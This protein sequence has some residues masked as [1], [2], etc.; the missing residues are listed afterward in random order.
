MKL[1]EL[2]AG[3]PTGRFVRDGVTVERAKPAVVDNV[4][5]KVAAESWFVISE[6]TEQKLAKLADFRD[7]REKKEMTQPVAEPKPKKGK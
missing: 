4:S 6:I 1:I 2:K 7:Y 5:A 3:H